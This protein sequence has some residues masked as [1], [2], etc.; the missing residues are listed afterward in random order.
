[1][2]V[3]NSPSGRVIGQVLS[4]F[5]VDASRR[6]GSGHVMA[7]QHFVPPIEEVVDHH[8]DP[9]AFTHWSGALDVRKGVLAYQ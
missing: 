9:G 3:L 6:I 2:E 4:E 7:P 8:E 1:M 5:E